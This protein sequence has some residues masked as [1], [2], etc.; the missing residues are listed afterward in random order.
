MKNESVKSS[1][2]TQ[3]IVLAAASVLVRIIGLIYRI[4]L[5][6]IIGDDGLGAYS[7]AFEVYNIALLLS[8]YS[9]PTAMSKLISER[10]GK[11]EYCNSYHLLQTG[12]LFSAIVGFF[13][14]M[15]LFVGADF[16]AKYIYREADL[17][18]AIPL[19]VLAPTI[20]IFSV[21]GVIRGFFQ[22]K[23]TVMPTSISQV[24]EQIVNAVVSVVAAKILIQYNSASPQISAYG[25]AGGTLGTLCGAITAFIFLVAL[26]LMYLPIMK[27]RMR[28]DRV[29]GYE[30]RALL[31][32][33]LVFTMVPIIL[34]QT[35]YSISSLM[36][37][38]LL[39]QI[40]SIKGVDEFTR[41]T[42]FGR[43]STKYRLMTNVPI[44]I[45]SAIGMAIIPS[46]VHAHTSKDR[47]LL[48][49]RIAQ[50]V[51][52]NMLIAFPCAAGM[53][54]LANPIMNA[55]FKD[56]GEALQMTSKMMYIGAV[57]IV[58]FAYSTTTNS[59]LQG[60]SRL[61][62]PVQ[63]GSISLVIYLI[64]DVILLAFTPLGVYALVIGNMIFPLIICVLN[65]ISLRKELDY[66]QEIDKTFFR[67]G[68]CTAFMAVFAYLIF[69]GVYSIVKS[70]ILGMI[71]AI[72]CAAFIY[73]V[74][75]IFFR[76][77]NEEELNDLPKGR[78]LVKIAKKLHMM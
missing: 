52:L 26:L 51:K 28:K 35:V 1:F 32:K 58:F 9:I 56:T 40:F 11:K 15:L 39:N 17:S 70:N 18:T 62:L 22:G 30:D 67:I 46:V 19:R 21:M 31:L 57:S 43:Y 68:L 72:P 54:V 55:I 24:L 75:L 73:F 3:G 6:R 69:H 37:S 38:V 16:I 63:H 49:S 66:E 25:A 59:I 23:H 5:A 64:L 14:S 34:N 50:A 13:A 65:W 74:L 4:P 27:K 12:L 78:L 2:L 42:L 29:G 36:D 7:N 61:R 48:H 71:V 47:E 20:F 44:A 33:L 53:A 10:E 60:V 45:A 77:V 76:A 8:T 41:R